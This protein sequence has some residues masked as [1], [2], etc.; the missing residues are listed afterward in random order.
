VALL[1]GEGAAEAAVELERIGL[2]ELFEERF[3]SGG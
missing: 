2:A 3:K 1:E